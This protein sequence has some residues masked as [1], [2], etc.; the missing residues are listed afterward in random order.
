MVRKKTPTP[1]EQPA[2]H[3]ASTL[4]CITGLGA[5]ATAVGMML[6]GKRNGAMLVAQWV[7]PLLI[8]AAHE[9]NVRRKKRTCTR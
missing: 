8:T 3:I 7:A 5:L 4:Y 9:Q 2:R 6:C 1:A